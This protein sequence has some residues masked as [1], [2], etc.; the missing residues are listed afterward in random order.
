MTQQLMARAEI[1]Q[2]LQVTPQQAGRIVNR[3]DF[4]APVAR[5]TRARIWLGADVERW[6]HARSTK[7]ITREAV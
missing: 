5:T 7:R 3:P 1:A 2:H 4:P 6:S